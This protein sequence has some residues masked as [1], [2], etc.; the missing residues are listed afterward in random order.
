MLARCRNSLYWDS[1][2]QPLQMQGS[3]LE[4]AS[5]YARFNTVTKM[6]LANAEQS[7]RE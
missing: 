4:N 3:L 5:Y 7:S 2:T 1:S 6:L